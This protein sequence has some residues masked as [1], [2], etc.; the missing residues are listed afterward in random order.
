MYNTT[1]YIILHIYIKSFF[2][3]ILYYDIH[4]T[5]LHKISSFI[6]LSIKIIIRCKYNY[7]IVLYNNYYKLAVWDRVNNYYK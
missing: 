3:D 7:Y 5:Y 2:I 4:Q 1:M 6:K